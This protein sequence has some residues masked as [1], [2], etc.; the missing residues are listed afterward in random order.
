VHEKIVLQL[1]IFVNCVTCALVDRV[2]KVKQ[3][4]RKNA[5]MQEYEYEGQI[6]Y[7][8]NYVNCLDK[9]FDKK[10]V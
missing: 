2:S 6:T 9:V 7:F 8:V 10:K 4:P 1:T 5:L 3:Q